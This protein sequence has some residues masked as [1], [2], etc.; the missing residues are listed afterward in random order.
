MINSGICFTEDAK[1]FIM[2]PM[3]NNGKKIW[4]KGITERDLME[5]DMG[6]WL[7]EIGVIANVQERNF[8]RKFGYLLLKTSYKK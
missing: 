8:I 5:I 3:S 7:E 6:D 4:R 2:V 1:E